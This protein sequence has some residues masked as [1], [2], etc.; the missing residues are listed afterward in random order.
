MKGKMGISS[1]VEFLPSLEKG[2]S[3]RFWTF[4]HTFEIWLDLVLFG[5]SFLS[6]AR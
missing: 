2:G 3:F 5:I 1:K 6:T 4:W